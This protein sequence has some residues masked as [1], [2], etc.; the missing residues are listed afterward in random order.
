MA[1]NCKPTEGF[2]PKPTNPPHFGRQGYQGHPKPRIAP[3]LQENPV[4]RN[5][6]G[7]G[8]FTSS[9]NLSMDQLANSLSQEYREFQSEYGSESLSKRFSSTNYS[10]S[11]FEELAKDPR[12]D[13][14]K[15][16]RCSIDEAITIFQARSENK[17]INPTRADKETARLVDLDYE[18][19]GLFPFTHFDIKTLVGSEILKKQNQTASLEDMAYQ[20]GQKI[21]TQKRKFVGLE[22]AL[23][24]PENVGHL[25]DL[26]Y[27][28]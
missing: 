9:K 14:V 10:V 1:C 11:E 21:V 3:K 16:D 7:Q 26:C 8:N 22:N 17:V 25:V 28:P 15:Y 23:V 5:N 2:Q 19:E 4:N 24:G 6:A 13:G 20:I 12:A 27:V 18:V